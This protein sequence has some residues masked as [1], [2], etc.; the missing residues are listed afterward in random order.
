VSEATGPA[1]GRAHDDERRAPSTGNGGPA[2]LQRRPLG[3]GDAW[4]DGP[5][6]R[7][8][9]GTYGAAGLLVVSEDS[10]ILLQHRAEWSHFGGTWGLPGGARHRDEN[11]RDG[12]VRE[13]AEEAGVPP[14]S[15]QPLFLSRLDLGW[16]SYSTVVAATSSPFVPVIGDAES[17]EVRWVPLDDVETLPLHPSFAERWPQ[18]RPDLFRR[19]VVIV[20]AANVVGSRP[21]G[22]W[23]D[24]PGAAARLVEHLGA[25]GD[26]GWPAA[27][28][29]LPHD[30]WW[31]NV[32]VV[33][34]GEAKR[35]P[36]PE[37]AHGLTIVRA[38]ADGDSAIVERTRSLPDPA[39]AIVV[40]ADRGLTQRVA[41]LG[42]AV[43]SPAA[44]LRAADAL[45]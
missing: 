21:D 19:P 28:L 10:G 26:T 41:E 38:D 1:G 42:A 8:F 17:I 4:V 9:W 39:Q 20:D 14:E 31:P 43:A 30:A 25:L 12:A 11:A 27:T 32:I 15:V 13:A 36:Q 29:G 33:L 44:L 40:T 24:R 16:W 6:G 3:S 23:R 2:H 37:H 22:W 5:D 45:G 7:R 34:E 35:M 18:L